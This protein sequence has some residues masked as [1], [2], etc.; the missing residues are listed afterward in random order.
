SHWKGLAYP[1]TAASALQAALLARQG[2]T[3]PPEV[4][5]GNKG[6]MDSVAGRFEI[7]WDSENLERVTGTIIKKYNA[8][9]HSQS[10]LEALIE[11][12][13]E[14]AIDP[15]RIESI[16]LEVFQVAFDIIGGGEEG[17]K[18]QIRT[19][20]EADHALP[21]MLA[22]AALDGA[23]GPRQYLPERIQAKD[24][25]SL[26]RRVTVRP[27]DDLSARFPEQH[28]CRLHVRL[29]DGSSL[30]AVKTDY[31]GFTTRPTS[32]DSVANKLHRLGG[33]L[34][35]RLRERL[36]EAVGA[37]PELSARAFTR[38]LA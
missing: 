20:E 19:K 38:S 9:I 4:F 22:V 1:Y 15:E 18:Q 6:F 30:K 29:K 28:A 35:L 3:G 11:L 10:A 21:Y 32:W 26:M 37:L 27:A 23:V 7:D 24:V 36:V 5:E 2:I 13:Q 25:Q 17:D 12:R 34:E 33:Q 31:E 8:E 14:H 16:E